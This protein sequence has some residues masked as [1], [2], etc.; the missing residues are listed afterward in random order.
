MQLIIKIQ[1]NVKQ[2]GK[3][4]YE[5]THSHGLVLNSSHKLKIWATLN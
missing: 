3:E 5:T 4:R 1:L 2:S